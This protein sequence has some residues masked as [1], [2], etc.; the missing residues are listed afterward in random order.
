MRRQARAA[1]TFGA[2]VA[3]GLLGFGCSSGGSGGGAGGSG[4][5]AGGGGGGAGGA[6]GKG[7]SGGGGGGAIDA[8]RDAAGGSAGGQGGSG[9]GGAGGGGQDAGSDALPA[10]STPPDN[11]SACN[12]NPPC[13]K[14]CGVDI[15]GLTTSRPQLACTCSGPSSANGKWACATTAGSCVYPSDIDLFCFRI[16]TPLPLCP[17]DPPD[18][19]TG[20]IRTGTSTCTNDSSETCS[21]ICGS[22]SSTVMSYRD[23]TGAKV[24][25]CVCIAGIWQC[26]SVAEWPAQ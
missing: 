3:L 18:G 20:L 4:G 16:P 21:G 25:Y 19:G 15:S 5:G 2:I 23:G 9:G 14:P 7:G 17:T 10:C 12:S 11:G 6:G 24:G 26:A 8:G 13:T 22:A 1:A